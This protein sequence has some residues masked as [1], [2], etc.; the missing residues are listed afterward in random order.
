EPPP[1]FRVKRMY[2]DLKMDFPVHVVPQPGSDQ[3]MV[4]CLDRA[5]VS[6]SIYR[7]QDDPAV[8]SMEM[9]LTSADTAV[10]LIF[11]P[12]FAANGYFYVGSNG[13]ATPEDTKT[14]K[15]R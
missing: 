7:M 14:K 10:D 6:T 1:P 8:T 11:H 9:L 13:P 2:P 5:W 12:R 3:L 4:I 15:S